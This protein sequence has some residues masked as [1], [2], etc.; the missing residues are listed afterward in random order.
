MNEDVAGL[1]ERLETQLRANRVNCYADGKDRFTVFD[2]SDAVSTI[3]ALVVEVAIHKGNSEDNYRRSVAAEAK[4][5][6]A[7][8]VMRLVQHQ[9]MNLEIRAILAT[10]EKGQYQ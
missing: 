8:E 7:V 5:R 10:M 4:L 9:P 1:V 2:V 3:R 6:E